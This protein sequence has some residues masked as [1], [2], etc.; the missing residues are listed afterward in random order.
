MISAALKISCGN[1]AD[2]RLLLCGRTQPAIGITSA[3]LGG[4]HAI[5]AKN[6]QSEFVCGG[7]EPGC[8][9]CGD[10][11]G[12]GAAVQP[13]ALRRHAMEVHWPLPRRANGGRDGCARRAQPLLYG[14]GEWRSVEEH[15]LRPDVESY[16]RRAA[17]T[18]GRLDRG[19]AIECGRYLCRERRRVA[20]AGPF[21]GR[22][23]L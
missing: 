22:R 23:N 2:S 12:C 4:V 6:F 16:F 18:I 5:L 3:L 9:S 15:G 1:V 13:D 7:C 8:L 11:A 21:G 10:F 20:A 17:D 19:G 14:T